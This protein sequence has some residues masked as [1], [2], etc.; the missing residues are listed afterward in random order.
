[1]STERDTESV[2]STDK[3]TEKQAFIT[4]CRDCDYV[5]AIRADSIEDLD[6]SGDDPA[7]RHYLK[8]DHT[9]GSV[10]AEELDTD[11]LTEMVFDV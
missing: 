9:V 10:P 1:M 3:Q 2:S 6:Q 8:T 11:A 5:D 4:V 7:L